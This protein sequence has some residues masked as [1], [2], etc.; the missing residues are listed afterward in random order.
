MTAA[1]EYGSLREKIAAEKAARLDRYAGFTRACELAHA[2]GTAAAEIHEPEPMVVAQHL[3][4]MDDSSPVTQAWLVP[5]GVCGFA[6]VSHRPASDSF[7]R[8]ASK[9]GWGSAYGGGIQ[10]WVSA[11]GQSYERKHAYAVAYAEVLREHG[12]SANAGGRLD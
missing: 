9:H 2:A 8:W 3:H 7:G 11:Y 6:W 12:I 4:P 1:P 10:L 5:D